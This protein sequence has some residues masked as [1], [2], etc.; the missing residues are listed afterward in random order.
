MCCNFFMCFG[1]CFES[2]KRKYGE[3]TAKRA[4]RII[5]SFFIF[6]LGVLC[7]VFMGIT[8]ICDNALIELNPSLTLPVHA[9]GMGVFCVCIFVISCISV[10]LDY[11]EKYLLTYILDIICILSMAGSFAFSAIGI[12]IIITSNSE[13]ITRAIYP[14]VK[15]L[16]TVYIFVF[17]LGYVYLTYFY[18][19]I[20]SYKSRN[21]NQQSNPV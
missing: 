20:K 21:K 3:D 13:C 18:Q 1:S 19:N 4:I 10:I 12:A 2:I 8:G 7:F 6:I 17:I 14:A 9:M 5:I 11:F 15:L 16:L